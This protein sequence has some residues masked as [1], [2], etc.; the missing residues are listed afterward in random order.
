MRLKNKNHFFLIDNA[1]TDSNFKGPYF[2]NFT[3]YKFD[4][5]GN[6]LLSNKL[7]LPFDSCGRASCP[8]PDACGKLYFIFQN[9]IY[10]TVRNNSID[11]FVYFRLA[12]FQ[13]K[14]ISGYQCIV[15]YD[16][17][18]SFS[19]FFNRYFHCFYL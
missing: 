3:L 14:Y 10:N 5:S 17:C 11:R 19:L 12:G 16:R 1:N 18:Y 2:N 7:T 6:I 8:Y 13:V 9:V 4:T 15:N